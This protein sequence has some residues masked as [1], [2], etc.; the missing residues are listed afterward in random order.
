MERS[1]QVAPELLWINHGRQESCTR[2]EAV[3]DQRRT[4]RIVARGAGS[5]AWRAHDGINAERTEAVP[6]YHR[7]IC[8]RCF[9]HLRGQRRARLKAL[10]AT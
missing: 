9:P 1:N 4:A 2:Q 6:L 5:C 3:L 10:H 7:S 8:N